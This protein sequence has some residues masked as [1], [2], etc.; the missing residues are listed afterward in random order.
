MTGTTQVQNFADMGALAVAGFVTSRQYAAAAKRT[1]KPGFG[2][3]V[4]R[5]R[6][7]F[8][9][10][11]ASVMACVAGRFMRVMPQTSAAS[12]PRNQSGRPRLGK[13]PA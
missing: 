4:N 3:S 9:S 1:D 5:A 2:I 6:Q 11:D 10:S 13:T 8:A 12:L 7:L